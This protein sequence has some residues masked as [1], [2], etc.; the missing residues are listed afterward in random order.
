MSAAE[1]LLILLVALLVFG[2]AKL[3]MLAQHLGKFMKRMNHAKNQLSAF[4][5]EQLQEHQLQENIKK[6]EKADAHYQQETK[7]QKK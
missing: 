3:P 4:W 6:A 2:P 1:L 7:E 5:N